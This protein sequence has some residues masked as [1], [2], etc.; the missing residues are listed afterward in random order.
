MAKSF[1]REMADHAQFFARKDKATYYRYFFK[2]M[3]SG[4]SGVGSVA[5]ASPTEFVCRL[6]QWNRM[7][8]GVWVYWSDEA[9]E[10]SVLKSLPYTLSGGAH[11]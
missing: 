3:P 4:Q 11:E 1:L 10:Q 5:C 8:E 7:A 6:A 2:Q 9:W